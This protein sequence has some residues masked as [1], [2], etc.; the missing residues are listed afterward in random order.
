MLNVRRDH[1]LRNTVTDLSI[2]K[3]VASEH[4]ELLVQT[5]KLFS[6]KKEKQKEEEIVDKVPDTTQQYL[7][8]REEDK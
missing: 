5:H 2:L 6:L 3:E 7:C 1:I 4:Q 8:R